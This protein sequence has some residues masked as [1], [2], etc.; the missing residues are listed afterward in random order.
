[1]S[2]RPFSDICSELAESAKEK[3]QSLLAYLLRMAALDAAESGVRHDDGGVQDFLV[4]VWDWDVVNDCVYAD[5]RFAHLF[6]ISAA[7][8]AKGT[9]LQAWINAVHP[10]DRGRLER[11][12]GRAL[13]GSLF[14]VEYR[15]VT[16]GETRWLYARGKCT[17]NREGRAVRFPGAVV[18]IT[19]EKADDHVSIVP[20]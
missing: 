20:H 2:S 3:G 11:E 9:P 19:H 18:D 12:I 14:S 4:G 16:Q 8:A 1:M 10:D 6:G 15:V 5:A 17:L 7:A 13:K